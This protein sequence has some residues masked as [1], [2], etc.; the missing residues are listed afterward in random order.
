MGPTSEEK[1]RFSEISNTVYHAKK[2]ID[3]EY[4]LG[5]YG[6]KYRHIDD[7]H[8]KTLAVLQTYENLLDSLLN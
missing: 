7:I 3:G 5:L 1:E 4:T 8:E 6:N 2:R